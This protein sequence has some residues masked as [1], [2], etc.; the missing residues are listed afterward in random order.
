MYSY[1]LWTYASLIVVVGMLVKVL[2]GQLYAC[3]PLVVAAVNYAFLYD[4][5]ILFY[6]LFVLRRIAREV[7]AY[8]HFTCV[9]II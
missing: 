4:A 3:A 5:F 1:H 6:Y 8:V 7:F 2:M 9:I